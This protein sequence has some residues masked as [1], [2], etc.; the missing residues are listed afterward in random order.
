MVALLDVIDAL[1]AHSRFHQAVVNDPEQADLIAARMVT[2][3]PPAPW[4]PEQAVWT[5]ELE[6]LA[7]ICDVLVA[8]NT[9]E[10]ETPA[11]YPR[12]QSLVADRVQALKDSSFDEY[13][14]DLMNGRVRVE[15]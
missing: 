12:P 8:A 7:T 3:P 9:G 15:I 4:R 5:P 14:D 6:I 10:G 11:P 2:A 13:L 1:P